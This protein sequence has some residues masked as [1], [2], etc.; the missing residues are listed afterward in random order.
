VLPDEATQRRQQVV[1]ER[2]W[3]SEIGIFFLEQLLQLWW[4]CCA[5]PGTG[6][7][8]TGFQC[9]GRHLHEV[10]R[11][12]QVRQDTLDR[13][14][15]VEAFEPTLLGE[16][17][18]GHATSG[19]TPDQHVLAEPNACVGW[20][21]HQYTPVGCCHAPWQAAI[22]G[23]AAAAT[24]LVLG[25]VAMQSCQRDPECDKDPHELRGSIIDLDNRN[26]AAAYASVAA[27][28]GHDRH[29]ISRRGDVPL[30]DFD[31]RVDTDSGGF[32]LFQGLDAARHGFL[33]FFHDL[34]RDRMLQFEG[35]FD[36]PHC[37]LLRFGI[38]KPR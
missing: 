15:P 34:R 22:G 32:F 30:F 38:H 3:S 37:G 18:F 36:N 16:K 4:G 2:R 20:H 1:T 8:A 19:N 25:V 11:I 14:A 7:S 27:T 23:V 31:D 17:H 26:A 5:A 33:V 21:G 9:V 6:G 12:D 24:G 28:G 10:R 29:S 35:T 13:D